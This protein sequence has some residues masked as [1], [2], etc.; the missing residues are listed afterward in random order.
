MRAGG[1]PIVAELTTAAVRLVRAV[2]RRAEAAEARGTL[3]CQSCRH[4]GMR[5]PILTCHVSA[6]A[7]VPCV[8]HGNGCLGWAPLLDELEVEAIHGPCFEDGV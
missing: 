6:V 5:G 1:R 2:T 4:S 7:A 8:L 3:R